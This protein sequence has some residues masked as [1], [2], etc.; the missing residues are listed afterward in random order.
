MTA[1]QVQTLIRM[2]VPMAGDIGLCIDQLDADS[3]YARVPF[4]AKLV[5]PGGTVSGPTIMALADAANPP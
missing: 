3:A 1:E 5:R 2:G 4:Q